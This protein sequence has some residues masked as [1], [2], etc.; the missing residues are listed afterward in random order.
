MR[1]VYAIAIALIAASVAAADS[2]SPEFGM[3]QST[4]QGFMMQDGELVEQTVDRSFRVGLPPQDSSI[5]LF[6]AD[7]DGD[8]DYQDETVKE[9][10]GRWY[11]EGVQWKMRNTMVADMSYMP[12]TQRYLLVL[13]NTETDEEAVIIMRRV[14]RW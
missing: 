13:Y 1:I 3:Y 10:S 8:G 4:D 9:H 14:E 11:A 5:I 2:Q 7:T 6:L 12:D